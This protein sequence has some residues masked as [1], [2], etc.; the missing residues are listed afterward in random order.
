MLICSRTFKLCLELVEFPI[1]E[2][3]CQYSVQIFQSYG[4]SPI[5]GVVFARDSIVIDFSQ[6]KA[7]IDVHKNY[8]LRVS[9]AFFVQAAVTSK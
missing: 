8:N 3:D 7:L 1:L 2:K 4:R 5:Y 9:L 6:P